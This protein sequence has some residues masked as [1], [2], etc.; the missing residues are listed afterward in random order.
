MKLGA[1]GIPHEADLSTSAGG[2]G[3]EYY[4][5]MAPRAVGFLAERLERERLR[6][7]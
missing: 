3:W 4:Q 2:H 1:L 7:V 5:H 6:V